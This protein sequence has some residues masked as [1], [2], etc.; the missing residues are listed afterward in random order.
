MNRD[1][2]A[3]IAFHLSG[4]ILTNTFALT[5]AKNQVVRTCAVSRTWVACSDINAR[6]TD[7]MAV[8]ALLASVH[9]KTASGAQA[10]VSHARRTSRSTFDGSTVMVLPKLQL[11]HKRWSN[12][13]HRLF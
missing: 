3:D 11:P 13:P 2:P 12:D 1:K 4:N 7:D 9:I 10:S 8:P 5:Y 6:S